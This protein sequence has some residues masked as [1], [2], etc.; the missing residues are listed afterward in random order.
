MRVKKLLLFLAAALFLLNTALTA[1]NKF[2]I[3]IYSN[4][5][6]DQ[7]GGQSDWDTLDQIKNL[8]INWI[9]HESR[10]GNKS[11]LESL[12]DSVIASNCYSSDMDAIHYYSSG[13]YSKWEAEENVQDNINTVG[14]K[15]SFGSQNT[16]NGITYWT[17]GTSAAY[18]DSLLMRGPN[19]HQDKNY[20]IWVS[21]QPIIYNLTFRLKR[22]STH[23]TGGYDTLAKVTVSYYNK[24]VVDPFYILT[25]T[26]SATQFKDT[27]FTYDF[28]SYHRGGAE[29]SSSPSHMNRYSENILDT[30]NVQFIVQWYGSY[31]LMIDYIEVMDRDIWK[32]DYLQNNTVALQKIQTQVNN[33]S[34]WTKLKYMYALDEPGSIDNYIPY[35][36]IQNL[37]LGYGGKPLITALVPLDI[38][39]KAFDGEKS[40]PRWVNTAN[41]KK[42]MFDFYPFN[43]QC[44]DIND[45]NAISGQF[46]F[47]RNICRA[48]NKYQK[49]NY[50]YVG[51]A[52]AYSLSNNNNASLHMPTANE[53]RA[54]SL[55]ALAHGARGLMYY[56][57]KSSYSIKNN[58]SET[59]SG[60]LNSNGTHSDLWDEVQSFTT[61]MHGAFGDN[62]MNLE[63]NDLSLRITWGMDTRQESKNSDSYSY[64]T[65]QKPL[66]GS[67][68]KGVFHC[69]LLS[70]KY[71][72]S[73]HTKYFLLLNELTPAAYSQAVTITV[74]KPAS[75]ANY[76]LK[77]V[78]GN[79]NESYSTSL[80]KNITIPAGNG[81]LFY[82]GPTVKCGGTIT[83]NETVNTTDT[84]KGALTIASGA[85]LT[86]NNTYHA[87]ND[88]TIDNGGHLIVNAGKSLVFH[89]GAK[90][91]VNGALSAVG[92][93]SQRITI[94]FSEINASSGNGIIINQP[95][96]TYLTYCNISNAFYGLKCN[97]SLSQC[98]YN[99]ITNNYTG[100]TFE[101]YYAPYT[102]I[103][104]CVISNNSYNGIKIINS[105]LS[106]LN[107]EIRDNGNTG[108]FCYDGTISNIHNNRITGNSNYGIYVNLNSQSTIGYNGGGT[109][110]LTRNRYG[111]FT[112]NSSN[113]TA[114]YNCLYNN[115]KNSTTQSPGYDIIANYSSTINARY[116]WWGRN[117][118]DTTKIYILPGS[119]IDY[120]NA[121][122]S[123]ICGGMSK[124]VVSGNE[125]NQADFS[126]GK[127][128]GQWQPVFSTPSDKE[129]DSALQLKNS[130]KYDDAIALY[131]KIL[132]KEVNTQK[133][134]FAFVGLSACYRDS[135]KDGFIDYITKSVRVRNNEKEK[136]YAVS[137]ELE[138]NWLVFSKKYKDIL[139]NLDKLKTNYPDNPETAKNAIFKSGYIYLK[140]FN[141]TVKAKAEF[142]ML[143]SKYP[144]D[145]LVYLS[146]EIL[147]IIKDKAGKSTR[148]NNQNTIIIKNTIP[149]EFN[150]EQNYPNPFNPVTTINYSLPVDSKV[151]LVVYNSLGQEVALLV[152]NVK[153]AGMHNAIFNAAHLS[154]GVYF[155]SLTAQPTDGSRKD[156][157]SN[158]KMLLIK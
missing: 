46:N 47:L 94:N 116:N 11:K 95:G 105:P 70:P 49:N 54:A 151:K 58:I 78:E 40:I 28:T 52:H 127:G 107:C 137:L 148:E 4:A 16:V 93:S 110:L 24:Q 9:I 150:L 26:V 33:F 75:F 129:L 142:D 125:N 41:P 88:I 29:A 81:Y 17:S 18:K 86:I 156:Y 50:I 22:G 74:N 147:G 100:I 71:P 76:T 32:N 66:S 39:T 136:I 10:A 23:I 72:D 121:Q 96:G 48:A 20:K 133:G 138:N 155:Y 117:P 111:L 57:Y 157:Q 3:G 154:S 122:T 77:D 141:D 99:N 126:L 38:Y 135:K 98:S 102:E 65:I 53:F 124:I 90:L 15:H 27:T 92:N 12:F 19:Y 128:F 63:Y 51:Q 144:D 114:N 44:P 158:K 13:Y 82:I 103:N 89:N 146:Q 113:T 36:T 68:D 131:N 109:N 83:A 134:I 61:R 1:Q 2:P 31:E 43:I 85:S 140:Y 34:N 79:F 73:V 69:G 8:G 60:L 132:I 25:S 130:R 56:C 104:G 42:L 152:D 67:L 153:T 91:V 101:D 30:A 112:S 123:S 5:R 149:T 62:L 97:G 108:I 84:L 139:A 145:D 115:S 55:L 118:P 120:S 7:N 143:A 45:V 80:V 35:K 59:I 21:D 6:A 87:Y 64:L 119:S 106:I 37:V 14:I